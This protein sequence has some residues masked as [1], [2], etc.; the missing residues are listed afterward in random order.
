MSEDGEM[1]WTGG[2]NS[3]LLFPCGMTNIGDVC[4]P[5]LPE[6]VGKSGFTYETRKSKTKK[7][8]E[9]VKL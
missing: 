4:H 5:K 8:K 3:K 2:I 9:T 6:L 7:S 1:Q